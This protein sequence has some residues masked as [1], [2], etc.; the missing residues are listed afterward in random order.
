MEKAFIPKKPVSVTRL[1]KLQKHFELMQEF[2]KEGLSPKAASKKSD[3]TVASA[4][5]NHCLKMRPVSDP[6]EIWQWEDWTW[7]VR[8]K[9]QAD[10]T[11]LFARWY[12]TVFSP[13]CPDGE[14]G[15]V[16]AARVI[17][18]AKRIK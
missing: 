3:K 8:K 16:Y 4:K 5:K 11:K 13:I 12:C 18:D 14:E 15:D 7:F 17:C 1:K 10:D 6:Y 2:M 9:W